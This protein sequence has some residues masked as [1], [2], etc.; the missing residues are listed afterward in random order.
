LPSDT[1]V[2]LCSYNEA[3]NIARLVGDLT[4]ADPTTHMVIIDDN[5]PD[6]TGDIA[7]ALAATLGTVKVIHRPSKLGL[8]SAH[9][10]GLTQAI[11]GGYKTAVTMDCDYTHSPYDVGKLLAA[12]DQRGADIAAGSRYSH[13]DGIHD[14][15]LW[16][17]VVTRTAHLCTVGLLGIPFDATS[18]FRAYR[19]EALRRVRYGDIR[20]D[21]YSFIFEMLFACLRAG[22][23]VVEVPLQMP[24]RQAGESKISRVEIARAI[25]TLA[26]LT[27]TRLATRKRSVGEPKDS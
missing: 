1:L 9:I 22:L 4:Q 3:G 2:I 8:G 25:V 20:G 12:L 18:A 17:K 6:G 24:I 10:L 7:D 11:E 14:W 16:R 27:R 13:P 19:T 26:R 21:G 5:S 23:K 15:P